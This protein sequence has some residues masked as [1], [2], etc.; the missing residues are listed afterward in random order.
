MYLSPHVLAVTE[1]LV[2]A[3]N[4]G[5]WLRRERT[6]RGLTL[7]GLAER[8]GGDLTY[9]AIGDWER[10]KREPKK[11]NLR[12]VCAA[13]LGEDASPEEVER[14]FW[15]GWSALGSHEGQP[16]EHLPDDEYLQDSLMAYSGPNPILRAAKA[17]AMGQQMI[18]AEEMAKKLRDAEAAGPVGGETRRPLPRLGRGPR[19]GITKIDE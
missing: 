11:L 14:L 2:M 10:G 19:K 17:A 1:P 7:E 9:V 16:V 4:F 13:L 8:T 3:E 6:G 18:S 15:K 12:I 5:E